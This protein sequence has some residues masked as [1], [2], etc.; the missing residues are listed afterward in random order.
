MAVSSWRHANGPVGFVLAEILGGGGISTRSQTSVA[1]KTSLSSFCLIFQVQCSDGTISSI[2]RGASD[3]S[4]EVGL[5]RQDRLML[6]ANSA[7][8]SAGNTVKA[9]LLDS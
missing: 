1:A 7:N 9:L 2:S 5:T 8:S 4:A 6:A 3:R